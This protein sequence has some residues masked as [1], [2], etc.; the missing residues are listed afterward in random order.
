MESLVEQLRI[1]AGKRTLGELVREREAAAQAI[2]HLLRKIIEG[3]ENAPR[4]T[5][6]EIR[7][8]SRDLPASAPNSRAGPRLVRLAEVCHTVGLSRSTI[9]KRVADGSFPAPVRVSLRSVRWRDSELS[10]WIDSH[11]G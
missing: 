6:R 4:L 1:D 11:V 2:E 9:Y 7:A 10:A 8:P 5:A 3:R